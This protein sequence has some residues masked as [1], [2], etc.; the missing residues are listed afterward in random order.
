MCFYFNNDFIASLCLKL[1]LKEKLRGTFCKKRV[2][3]G[4]ITFDS[5]YG[6]GPLEINPPGWAFEF[7][8]TRVGF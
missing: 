8:P 4:L 6:Q 2:V 1:T 5:R 3:G 7:N